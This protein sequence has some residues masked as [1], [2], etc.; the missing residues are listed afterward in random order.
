M[1]RLPIILLLAL[2]LLFALLFV[3]CNQ[4]GTPA[5]TTA[6]EETTVA[7]ETTKK[8]KETEPPAPETE[9]LPTGPIEPYGEFEIVLGEPD[10]IYQAKES[11]QGWGRHQFP[12]IGYTADGLLRISWSDGE[13]V[14]G[15]KNNTTYRRVSLNGGKSWI[16]GTDVDATRAGVP[17]TNGKELMG[18]SSKGTSYA[19]N[20]DKYTPVISGEEVTGGGSFYLLSDLYEDPAMKDAWSFGIVEYDPATGKST[21]VM[22]NLHW[23]WGVVGHYENGATYTVSGKIAQDGKRFFVAEDGTLYTVFYTVALDS[24]ADTLEEDFN[25][26]Y[27]HDSVF[28]LYSKDCGRNWYIAKQFLPTEETKAMSVPYQAQ[29]VDDYEGFGEP[30]M[31][32]TPSGGFFILMRSG[33]NR[34]MF[35]STSEDGMNWTDPVP[36]DGVGVLP[37]ILTLDCGVTITTYGRPTLRVRATSDPT[38][39]T[40]EDPVI[41]PISYTGPDFFNAS[42]FY[43]GI[44]QI[45]ANTALMVYTDFKYP[46][47]DGIGARAI[48][49]RTIH[50]VPK[51]AEGGN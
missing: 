50:I 33:T 30:Y 38:C 14:V 46:N 29:Y 13:D 7:D 2:S 12:N 44:V 40:W 15:A 22:A 21:T 23:P 25:G 31:I 49:T 3:G 9:P 10:V 36:F 16:P 43:T 42:C 27:T 51:T 26:L 19:F 45:D 1:K 41:V 24:T 6:A 4:T 48:L 17:M 5:D 34:T 37:Q 11:V 8:P 28:V 47:K 20:F 39:A 35:Y 18:F 32:Q